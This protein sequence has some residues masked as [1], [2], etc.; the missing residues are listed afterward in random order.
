MTSEEYMNL[1]AQIDEE[2]ARISV[3]GTKVNEK[4][5]FGMEKKKR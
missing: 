2:R 1:E 5:F 4:T 3:N